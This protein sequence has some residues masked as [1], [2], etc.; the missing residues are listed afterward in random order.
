VFVDLMD[1]FLHVDAELFE[2]RE[3]LRRPLER[4]GVLLAS[5]NRCMTC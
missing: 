1:H 4:C 3:D 5:G 2:L